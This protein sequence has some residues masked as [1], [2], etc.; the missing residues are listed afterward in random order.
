MKTQIEYDMLGQS[1]EFEGVQ[2]TA[3]IMAATDVTVL[4][5]GESGTGKEL[6][7]KYIHTQSKRNSA[8]LVT[9]NCAALPEAL[10]ESELFGHVRGAFTGASCDQCGRIQSA[11]N[12]TL[13]LDEVGELPLSIQAKLLRFLEEGE[14]QTIGQT[15][16][17]KVNV[18]VIAATNRD[19]YKEVEKGNF[20]EDLFYRLNVVPLALP[21]LRDRQSDI[22]YL[23]NHLSAQ[24]AAK[25]R[26]DVPRYNM[27]TIEHC[28]RY[29]WPG[30][31]R[32]LKNF[33]E[34]MVILLSGKTIT[35]DNL[36]LEMKID[37]K[38]INSD[39]Y[40]LPEGGVILEQLEAQLINQAMN[41]SHGNQSKAARLL[42]LTRSAL[43]YR[44]KKHAI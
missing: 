22:T 21:S 4:I 37:Q 8:S 44:M 34:R 23:I 3:K 15:K 32:E 29:T 33:C 38:T 39:P 28:Q 1:A 36:P 35:V 18:R 27:K 6:M 30:N 2:R 17:K 25:H 13:F 5:Q 19:L 43:L 12:G 9:I 11:H 40:T 16:T 20:R 24:L 31:I 41:K 10:A 7:A 42:G 14:C 26:L